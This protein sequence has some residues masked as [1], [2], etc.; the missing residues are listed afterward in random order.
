MAME[1]ARLKAIKKQKEQRVKI[2]QTKKNRQ[3]AMQ[4]TDPTAQDIVAQATKFD[5]K[6]EAWAAKN[7]WFG[8][9]NAMTYTAFDIHRKLVEEEGL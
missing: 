9:D 8:T 1:E 7:T 5:P 4:Q 2:A 3:P 6:A